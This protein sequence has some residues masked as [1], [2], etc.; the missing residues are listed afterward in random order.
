MKI[1][2]ETISYLHKIFGII[3]L[4]ITILFLIFSKQDF[5]DKV[6]I[7]LFINLYYHL[8]YFAFVMFSKNNIIKRISIEKPIQLFFRIFLVIVLL[9]SFLFVF[10]RIYSSINNNDYSELVMIFMQ[11]GLFLG[12]I[13]FWLNLSKE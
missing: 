7:I 4:G 3:N 1:T 9:S 6:F 12:A 8:C 11:V 5:S 2:K 10:E 13:S